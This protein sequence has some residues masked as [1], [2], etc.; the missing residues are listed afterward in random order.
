M[1]WDTFWDAL[2]V[3]GWSMVA[4]LWL[5]FWGIRWGE[6]IG[7]PF[8]VPYLMLVS[9]EITASLLWGWLS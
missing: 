8:L 2:N 6:R 5:R 7:H 9:F 3:V 4:A 1:N